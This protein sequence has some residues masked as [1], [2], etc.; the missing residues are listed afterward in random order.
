MKILIVDDSRATQV[1]VRRVIEQLPYN[2]IAIANA[3]NGKEGLEVIRTWEPDLIISD[4]HMPEMTGIDMLN[5]L[6]REMLGI[7]IGFI[8]TESAEE[9]KQE[10]FDSGAVFYVQKPFTSMDLQES[11]IPIIESQRRSPNP[12]DSNESIEVSRYSND[13][14]EL[15]I[16]LIK[17]FSND[18]VTVDEI[19]PSFFERDQFPCVLA[20]LETKKDK[21]IRALVLFDHNASCIIESTLEKTTQPTKNITNKKINDATLVQC[22]LLSNNINQSILS[23]KDSDVLQLRNITIV[24]ENIEVI[25]S[26]MKKSWK[27]RI[28]LNI[29]YNNDAHGV[30]T[31]ISS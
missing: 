31:L 11:L 17:Q 4:W 13:K 10:A 18:S 2:S 24:D 5:A 21:K 28:D 1:I 16:K 3:D 26:L 8:S 6:K 20:L 23:D 29:H 27:K 30:I 19:D 9:K 22:K 14:R 15:L 7:P 12:E 25:E